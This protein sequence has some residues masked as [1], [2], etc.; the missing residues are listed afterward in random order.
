MNDK[1]NLFVL[2]LVRFLENKFHKE[3]S[4]ISVDFFLNDSGRI[5]LVGAEK[6]LFLGSDGEVDSALDKTTLKKYEVR[7]LDVEIA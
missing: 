4:E 5:Y 2:S 6:I 7:R 3:I 1:C